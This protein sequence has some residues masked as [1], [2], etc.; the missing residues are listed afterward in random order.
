MSTTT[1]CSRSEYGCPFAAMTT[2]RSDRWWVAPLASGAFLALCIGY[3]SWAALQSRDFSSGPYISPLYSPCVASL[4][5]T[6]ANVVLFGT[7]WRWSPA[8]IVVAFPVGVR[9]TCYYYRKLYYR[10][11]WLA[12]PACAVAEPHR[13]SSGESRWPLLLQNTHRYFWYA[14]V[15]VALMLSVDSIKAF[16]FGRS[17]GIGVG[18]LIITVNA[19]LFWGYLL[20][21]HAFRHLVGGGLRSFSDHPVRYRV[22]KMTSTINRHHGLLALI[23]LP[24]VMVTDGYVR[25]IASGVFPDPRWVVH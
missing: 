19:L 24:L 11:L 17:F 22:W 25:L 6:H 8:L 1:T 23:S 21:C 12:P 10:A 15:L 14:G 18:S 20:S 4:C 5:G 16:S 7:W 3:A 9:A 2:Y 13:R